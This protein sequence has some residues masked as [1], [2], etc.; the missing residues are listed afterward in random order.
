M[1]LPIAN[2]L[3]CYNASRKRIPVHFGHMT[4][5]SFDSQYKRFEV[6]TTCMFDFSILAIIYFDLLL[7]VTLEL[8]NYLILH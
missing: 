6:E 8:K 1:Q 7:Q 4:V 3:S 2:R 5:C